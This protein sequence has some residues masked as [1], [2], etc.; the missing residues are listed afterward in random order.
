MD[1]RSIDA[2]NGGT[3]CLCSACWRLAAVRRRYGF[4]GRAVNHGFVYRTS[5]ESCYFIPEVSARPVV[6]LRVQTSEPRPDA[7]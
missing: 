6:G 7:T 1:L 4:V 3:S 2:R 5:F